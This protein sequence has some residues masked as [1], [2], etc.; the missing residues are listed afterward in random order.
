LILLN[1]RSTS[2][3]RP[4]VDLTS[5]KELQMYYEFAVPVMFSE[6][7]EV[8]NGREL[9]GSPRVT[10]MLSCALRDVGFGMGT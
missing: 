4:G 10:N 7:C 9:T 5:D 3:G 1:A 8:C 6:S 2:K